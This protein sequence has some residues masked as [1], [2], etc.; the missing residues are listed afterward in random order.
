MTDMKGKV[1]V[2]TGAAS[3]LGKAIAERLAANGMQVVVADISPHGA[4][5]AQQ[6][7]GLFVQADSSQRK[8]CKR[9]IDET[10]ARYKAIHVLVN[11]AGFQHVAP[12]E[13]FPED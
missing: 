12:I 4:Q 10:L 1:A 6:I 9:L 11:N 2:V 3:G 13:E 7:G 5:V 8:E